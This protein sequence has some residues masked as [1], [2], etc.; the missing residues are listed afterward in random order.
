MIRAAGALSPSAAADRLAALE[1]YYTFLDTSLGD[2]TAGPAG[3]QRL[4]VLVT[5]PGRV[6]RPGPGLLA[7]SGGSA[8]AGRASAT[9]AAVAP[10]IL[11]ALGIPVARDLAS[12][13]AIE[14]FSR[15][16]ADAHPIRMVSSYGARRPASRSGS[17]FRERRRGSSSSSSRRTRGRC[18]RG[19]ERAVDNPP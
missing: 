9:L 1:Q 7:L 15:T 17:E 14:L 8:G 3:E 12:Q 19:G 10:T 6:E 5:Q 4:V 16:F 11:H 18:A 13:P 2:L